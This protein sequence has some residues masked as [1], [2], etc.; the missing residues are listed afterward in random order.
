[1]ELLGGE[2]YQ[3]DLDAYGIVEEFQDLG[4]L[5]CTKN[6]L[7]REIGIHFFPSC[8]QIL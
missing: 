1:M 6:D 2:P 4:I 3:D 5:H 7:S 8:F